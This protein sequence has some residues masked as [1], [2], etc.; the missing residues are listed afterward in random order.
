MTETTGPEAPPRRL[1]RSSTD[2]MLAGVCGGLADY[3]GIDPVVFRVVFAVAGL[4]GGA[5]IAAYLVAWLVIPEDRT[6][7]SHAES[8]LRDHQIPRFIL[9]PLAIVGVFLVANFI[10]GAGHPHMFGG[11]VTLIV[12]L[13]LGL[14]LWNRQ[15]DRPPRPLPAPPAPPVITP[16]AV[17]APT[18]R[19]P[20][21]RSILS[22]VTIS[23]ALVVAGF[24]ALLQTAGADITAGAILASALIVLGA[25]L[26][27]GTRWGRARGLIPLS[28]V[29]LAATAVVTIADVP[30]RGGAGERVWRPVDTSELAREYHLGAGHAQLDLRDLHLDGATRHVSITLGTGHLEIWLPPSASVRL[31]GHIGAGRTV[32]IGTDAGGIDF[33]KHLRIDGTDGTLVLDARVGLGLLEVYR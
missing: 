7:Q 27:V 18:P 11:G 19:R 17:A 8:I 20:K 28:L 32:G 10:D 1:T 25:G 13:V 9:V 3:T 33:D 12:L 16:E 31:D 14:W 22:A 30:F 4:L 23:A 29:L 24:L 15:E 2:R 6:A 26:L 5:G 21:E